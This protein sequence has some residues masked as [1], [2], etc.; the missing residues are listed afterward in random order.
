MRGVGK[1]RAD[2]DDKGDDLL[3]AEERNLE[4]EKLFREAREQYDQQQLAAQQAAAEQS[5]S[6]QQQMSVG[7]YNDC[8]GMGDA[9]GNM[10]MSSMQDGMMDMQDGVMIDMPP[11]NPTDYFRDMIFMTD[12]MV[13]N[14]FNSIQNENNGDGGNQNVEGEGGLVGEAPAH[15]DLTPID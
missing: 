7:G 4:Q 6:Q 8:N 12:F 15:A 2:R 3:T 13:E 1:S 11:F 9:A 10:M 5:T 14:E